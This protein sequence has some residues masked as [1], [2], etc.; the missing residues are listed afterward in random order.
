LRF[1]QIT[2]VDVALGVLCS[3][4]LAAT[5]TRADM[6]AIWWVL[7]PAAT[8]FV[9]ALDHL[10]DARR[11]GPGTHS[12][13]HRFFFDH[14][15][16]L[17]IQA[18]AVGTLGAAA[19][20]VW[21][22]Q[23]L[24]PPTLLV[25]GAAGVHIG[26]AQRPGPTFWPKELSAA[27]IYIAGIW[28]APLM[29]AP[30]LDRWVAALVGL[31]FLAALLNLLTFSLFE[32]RIDELDGEVSIPCTWGE[33]VTRAVVTGLTTAGLASGSVLLVLAPPRIQPA[34][35]VVLLLVALPAGMARFPGWFE[36]HERYRRYGD[37][38]FLLTVLPVWLRLHAV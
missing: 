16:M 22:P 31:H 28:F 7:A 23:E 24:W 9:Y 6:P 2:S 25:V 1:V 30:A 21:W 26:L 4:A 3:A 12:F 34:A 32:R 35:L 33:Q 38:A 11:K 17:S 18:V 14:R 19:A 29:L 8:W 36:E 15:R 5:V 10:L 13:R 20:L 27:S 37:L